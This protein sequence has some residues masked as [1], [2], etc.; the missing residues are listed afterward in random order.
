MSGKAP[1]FRRRAKRGAAPPPISLCGLRLSSFLISWF[2]IGEA[3][4]TVFDGS[5]FDRDA[6]HISRC[7]LHQYRRLRRFS[8]IGLMNYA[9]DEPPLLTCGPVQGEP[10][11]TRGPP[12]PRRLKP[13]HTECGIRNAEC[14]I[15]DRR[16][17]G[18]TVRE[19]S[20]AEARA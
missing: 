3:Y 19:G 13:G 7:G 20:F 5:G 16:V 18:P 17:R 8:E 9:L 2:L 6:T 4:A 1:P 10:L 12:T 11:L 14:G 15:P